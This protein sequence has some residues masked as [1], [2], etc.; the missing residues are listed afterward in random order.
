MEVP[1]ARINLIEHNFAIAKKQNC[2]RSCCT[3]MTRA[4]FVYYHG[5]RF[6]K[7]IKLPKT[8]LTVLNFKGKP[9]NF[10]YKQVVNPTPIL[11]SRLSFLRNRYI[12]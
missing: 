4:L 12:F 10:R 5:F 11:A 2:C 8:V 3:F 6:Y 7:H 9:N 1:S